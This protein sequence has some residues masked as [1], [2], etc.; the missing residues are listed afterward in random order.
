M[1]DNGAQ[2]FADALQEFEQSGDVQAFVGSVFA[3]DAELHR[4]EHRGQ[5]ETGQQGATA[6]WEQ[7]KSQF[8]E[9]ASTFSRVQ[10]RDGLGVLEWTS[11][12]RLS[13]GRPVRYEGV[14]VLDLGDDG[15]VTR[16]ATWYDTAA[17]LS[18]QD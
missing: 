18:P 2:R 17:F 3:D 15:K 8:D 9:I 6:F 10:E 7:Y 11:E 16:F 14:S 4:P 12:G 1:S 5:T 13:T